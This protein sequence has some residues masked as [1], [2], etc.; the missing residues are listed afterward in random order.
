MLTG[1]IPTEV[2]NAQKQLKGLY[3]SDNKLTGGIPDEVCALYKLENL[4]LDENWFDGALPSCLG[5]MSS[6]QRFYAFKNK[7]TGNVPNPGLMNLPH[8]I[9]VGIEETVRWYADHR[10]WWE[11]LKSGDYRRFYETHYG[12]AA[13]T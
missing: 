6:L 12:S 7:F 1:S 2:E 3:L 11:P 8:L 4:F 13:R 9:E 5:S 10:A